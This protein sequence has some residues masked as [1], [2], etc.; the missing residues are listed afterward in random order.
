MASTKSTLTQIF[1][2]QAGLPVTDDSIHK[3]LF[4]WWKNPRDKQE[5]GLTLT[6]EGLNHLK[7]TLGLKCYDIPFPKNFEFTT[8]II[9]FLD[10]F[11]D[12]PNYYNKKSIIIFNEKKAAELMLFAGDIRK[13][14]T[15]KA[16][17]RQRDL[18]S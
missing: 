5:G 7:N 8:Q 6:D 1:L 17:A 16:M 2:K 10:Q 11:I 12:C 15:A 4:K 9:L 13:F 14:G 3:A 18:N